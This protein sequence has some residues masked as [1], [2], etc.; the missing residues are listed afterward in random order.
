MV[1]ASMTG[2]TL[3]MAEAI[4]EG[5][6]EQEE[7]V[8]KDVIEVHADELENYDGI[9]LGAYTWGDGDLPDEF[10]DFYEEMNQINLKGKKAAVFGSCD[11]AYEQVGAAV[12][13]LIQKL[14]DQGAEVILEGLK[15]ELTPTEEDK[16]IC[17]QFGRDFILHFDKK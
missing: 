8:M 4:V 2:N 11:S 1:Y 17:R 16:E 7:V 15:I 13:I 5:I 3:D 12:D 10:I 9:L 6:N 14:I